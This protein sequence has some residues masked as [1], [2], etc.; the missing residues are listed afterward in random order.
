MSNFYL[1]ILWMYL[2]FLHCLF[3]GTYKSTHELVVTGSLYIWLEHCSCL[4]EK[5]QISREDKVSDNRQYN[6][7]QCITNILWF[8]ILGIKSNM[9]VRCRW[10]KLGIC[11]GSGTTWQSDAG[12]FCPLT[13]IGTSAVMYILPAGQ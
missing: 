11:S 6:M 10:K 2:H 1:N 5:Y 4:R 3:T 9:V 12:E 7:L 8:S 13:C